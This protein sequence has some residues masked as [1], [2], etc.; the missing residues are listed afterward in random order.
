VEIREI[1]Y[2]LVVKDR[3][4]TELFLSNELIS[5]KL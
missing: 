5:Y 4:Q 2:K 3:Y 1:S